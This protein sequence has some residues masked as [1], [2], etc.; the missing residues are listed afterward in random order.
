MLPWNAAR[1]LET[2]TLV[3]AT[4]GYW[5]VLR[6]LETAT[7]VGVPVGYWGAYCCCVWRPH[8]GVATC[9]GASACVI[10]RVVTNCRVACE[11]VCI[12]LNGDTKLFRRRRSVLA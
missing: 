10:A 6:T 11:E 4:V 9:V 2:V 1:T 12:V 8:G 3:G 5:A 7:R